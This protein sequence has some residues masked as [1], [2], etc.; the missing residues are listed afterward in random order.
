MILLV[1]GNNTDRTNISEFKKII[2]R[3]GWSCSAI[4][5]SSDVTRHVAR[6]RRDDVKDK[7]CGIVLS[8]GPTRLLSLNTN[9]MSHVLYCLAAFEDV[10]V[11]GVCLGFQFLNI[12]HGG[13]IRPFGR[14]V[15]GSQNL[16]RRTKRTITRQFCFNDVVDRVA[17]GFKVVDSAR[18]VDVKGVYASEDVVCH[19][20]SVTTG[21]RPLDLLKNSPCVN[22][23]YLLD[24]GAHVCELGPTAFIALGAG[25]V[26]PRATLATINGVHC[27]VNLYAQDGNHPDIPVL[28]ADFL[29]MM[30]AVLTVDYKLSTVSLAHS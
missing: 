13:S 6:D 23:F 4:R 27:H 2:R 21:R 10:P 7:V 18:V 9:T 30:S 26:P 17:P 16:V 3:L 11:L 19:I 22:V 15:C 24:T 20:E 8:G 25:A 5:D 14:E 12:V 1:D 29:T 28:G